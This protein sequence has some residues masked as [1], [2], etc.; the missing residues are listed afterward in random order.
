MNYEALGQGVYHLDTFY[1]NPG[2]ASM[3]C[4]V[5]NDEIAII[6]TGT[7][8]SL[9]YVLQ[10]LSDLALAPEQVKYIIPTHVHLDHAGGAG[11]MMQAFSNAQLVIHPRG[12]RHMID[13]GKL[14]AA[15]RAVYGD[16]LFN[17]IYGDIPAIDENRVI[18]GEH[19]SLIKLNDRELLI[20]DTPGHAYHHFCVVDLFSR[21]IFTGDTFGLAYPDLNY[22]NKRIVLPT[23]TPIHFNPAALHHSVNLLMSFQPQQMYMTHFNVLAQPADVVDQYREWIDKF[24]DLT[25]TIKPV[26]NSFLPTM[27][28]EMGEMIRHGFDL[29]QDIIEHKLAM[30][31][32]LNCQGLSFWYQHRDD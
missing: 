28:N 10:F 18:I 4:M 32:K 8:H 5:H 12:A 26:D 6:E 17:Q 21:G 3:Y 14:V 16:Q 23:T 31:I 22:Q 9:P 24:V 1:I 29:S 27:M 11:V 7:A 20:I 15:T 2:V 30:D 13:P 19:E 25:E